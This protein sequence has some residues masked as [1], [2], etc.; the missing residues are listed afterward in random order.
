MA[1]YMKPVPI[2]VKNP[3]NTNISLI[4]TPPLSL[5]VKNVAT[6]MAGYLLRKI[7]IDNYNECS[8]QLL[9]EQLPNPYDELSAYRFLRSKTYQE[10]GALVY[11]TLAMVQF[12]QRLENLSVLCLRPL[13]TCHFCLQDYVKV[14]KRNT[15]SLLVGRQNVFSGYRKWGNY[16][17]KFEF[18]MIE[19]RQWVQ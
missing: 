16:T 18:P 9:L 10:A 1:K 14:Q 7:P 8:D 11:P 12:V 15:N 2:N 5:P 3:P 19:M 13:Y 17:W 4:I 6:Y